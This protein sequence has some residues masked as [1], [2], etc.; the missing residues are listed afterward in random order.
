MGRIEPR[1]CGRWP[2]SPPISR[3][4]SRVSERLI[5]KRSVVRVRDGVAARRFDTLVAEEPM[6]LR[7]N[8][9]AVSVTMRTPGHD[10][11]LALGFCLTEG[12]I[13]HAQAVQG[14]RYC[15]GPGTDAGE[16]NVVD[17]GLRSAE[18][19]AP[20]LRRNVY[21]ASS[22]GLCGTAS[23]EAVRKRLPG[24]DDDDLQIPAGTL[25]TLPDRLRDRQRLFSRTGGLHAAAVFSREG[26]LL[27]VREDV[28]RHNAVD[29]VIGWA[30]MQ[31]R[32]PLDGT[33]LLVSGRIAFEIA[34]K[35]LFA[36]IPLVAAVSAPSSLAVSL[37]EDAG[38]TMVGFLRGPSMNVYT[39][40]DRVL[41]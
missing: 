40:S 5:A 24:V 33:V 13:P 29:K 35:A 25:A 21:T 23:I 32:L 28:G 10:F 15:A 20:E 9:D 11:E 14:V 38:M 2:R 31:D 6:E 1:V 39:R 18:R 37:A 3:V 4:S 7:V 12:L 19:I 27:C 34:Q 30:A 16:H 22:C 8:G 26:D 17:V 41:T 36:R